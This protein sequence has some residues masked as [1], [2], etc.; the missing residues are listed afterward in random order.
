MQLVKNFLN[1]ATHA[2]EL[3]DLE[4]WQKILRHAVERSERNTVPSL[5][6]CALFRKTCAFQKIHEKLVSREAAFKA[7][8]ELERV[9]T[10][11]MGQIETAS[12][13]GCQLPIN[14]LDE[15]TIYAVVN[16]GNFKCEKLEKLKQ[17]REEKGVF[18][19]LRSEYP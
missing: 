13:N 14:F 16:I 5:K 15:N 10:D 12:S 17:S 18:D 9:Y 2:K 7:S 11:L 19:M 3:S 1:F 8:E 4:K 6:K